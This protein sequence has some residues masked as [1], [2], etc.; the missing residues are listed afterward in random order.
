M[1]TLRLV[2][3]L[4]VMA[5][6]AI[7][8]W[9]TMTEAYSIAD[10]QA[11]KQATKAHTVLY[12][13]IKKLN[14]EEALGWLSDLEKEFDAGS[15]QG[16]HLYIYSFDDEGVPFI[17]ESESADWG[18][19]EE[20]RSDNEQDQEQRSDNEQ[21]QEQVNIVSKQLVSHYKQKE[22]KGW[23]DM[24]YDYTPEEL[25]KLD[26]WQKYLFTTQKH[27]K[28]HEIKKL[29]FETNKLV[30]TGKFIAVSRSINL[31]NASAKARQEKG[32]LI[33]MIAIMVLITTLLVL[34][35][36]LSRINRQQRDQKNLEQKLKNKKYTE[37]LWRQFDHD[38][39][40]PLKSIQQ[41]A[42]QISNKSDNASILKKTSAI[43]ETCSVIKRHLNDLRV[44]VRDG[45]TREGLRVTEYASIKE[46]LR[47]VTL[48]SEMEHQ[49]K[50][51]GIKKFK[52]DIEDGDVVTRLDKGNIMRAL[53][54]IILN[55]IRFTPKGGAIQIIVSTVKEQEKDFVLIKVLD[56]GRG[57]D[58][59]EVESFKKLSD[60][61]QTTGTFGNG[62]K[63]VKRIVD[64]HDG[65]II[66]PRNRPN[67]Q[68]A[69][70][71][72]KLPLIIPKAG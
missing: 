12:Q 48:N 23:D 54:N 68:G 51:A 59:H 45:E 52:I 21:D 15:L 67:Q 43:A 72:I 71:A 18:E 27:F 44:D 4:L 58:P 39:E 63:T 57:V 61:E 55:S 32:R 41:D 17:E 47:D 14:V 26:G 24:Y 11:L 56:T 50:I 28:L 34:V 13:A 66:M 31:L 42:I 10:K 6:S 49:R 33:L 46:L 40:H 60:D 37:R 35:F 69:E 3:V 36:L 65:E 5:G 38:I 62:L 30:P 1:N 64:A 2:S 20:Q 19:A 53:Q 22:K 70:V 25:K 7:T 9:Y 29:N 8:T 16:Y